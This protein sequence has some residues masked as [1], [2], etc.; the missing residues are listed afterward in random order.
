MCTTA[1]AHV[2]RGNYYYTVKNKVSAAPS[3]DQSTSQLHRKFC[4]LKIIWQDEVSIFDK[5][6]NLIIMLNVSLQSP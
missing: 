2:I 4:I 6:L 3:S 5:L 1:M